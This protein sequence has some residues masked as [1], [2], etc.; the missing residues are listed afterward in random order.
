MKQNDFSGISIHAIIALSQE[1]LKQRELE[2]ILE[3][4]KPLPEQVPIPTIEQVFSDVCQ[5]FGL[6]EERVKLK[7][8]KHEFVF[9]RHVFCYVIRR[10]RPDISLKNI[11]IFISGRDHTTVIH[12]CQSIQDGLD[13][14]DPV[15][16][17]EWRVFLH[18][19]KLFK[20]DA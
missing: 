13:S 10:I 4:K 8:R 9:A 11:G 6:P 15:F 16:W 14:K 2:L 19:T 18:N 20:Q 7:G 17:T 12:A 5:A 1:A 3:K